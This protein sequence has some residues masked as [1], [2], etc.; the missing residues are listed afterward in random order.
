[1]GLGAYLCVSAALF[2]LGL[3]CMVARRNL[4]QALLGLLLVLNAA[5]LDFVAFARFHGQASEGTVTA[6]LVLVIAGAEA[7]VALAIFLRIARISR[8]ADS[9]ALDRLRE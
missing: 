2:A 5:S 1:M 9:R 4:V 6:L 7:A 3:C 8:T